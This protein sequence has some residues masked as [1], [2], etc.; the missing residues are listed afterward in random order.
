MKADES[1]ESDG[2]EPEDAATEVLLK[3]EE[4]NEQEDKEAAKTRKEDKKNYE[5]VGEI[6]QEIMKIN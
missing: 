1:S 6:D 3:D 4:D 5:R 2:S